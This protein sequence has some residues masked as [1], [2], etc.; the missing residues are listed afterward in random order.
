MKPHNGSPVRDWRFSASLFSLTVILALQ[1]CGDSQ[2][3]LPDTSEV[4][5]RHEAPALFRHFAIF[6]GAPDPLPLQLAEQVSVSGD[7]DTLA[8]KLP[9]L[10]QQI[11][12]LPSP[13]RLCL[14][15]GSGGASSVGCSQIRRVLREGTYIASIPADPRGELTRSIAG[16]VPDGIRR[17]RIRFR[18]AHPQ[19]VDVVENTFAL[20]DQGRDFPESIQ[21][22]GNPK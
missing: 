11:W 16:L 12:A 13:G 1:G 10:T 9:L 15:G 20:R 6:R 21:L 22:I 7:V 8:Q 5:T 2:E 18:R 19:I 14:A 4:S 17:V 3:R